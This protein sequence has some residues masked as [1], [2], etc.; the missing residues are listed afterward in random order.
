MAD[1]LNLFQFSF[2]PAPVYSEVLIEFLAGQLLQAFGRSAA[3]FACQVSF[4]V[5][6]L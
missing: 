4:A 2:N 6:S 1:S 5:Q 3:L